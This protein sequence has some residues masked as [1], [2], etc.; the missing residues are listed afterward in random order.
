MW[1]T[2]IARP[3]ARACR[4]LGEAA[5]RLD[6]FDRL[7]TWAVAGTSHVSFIGFPKRAMEP[8]ASDWT[9]PRG[10][11][12]RS[13]WQSPETS[14]LAERGALGAPLVAAVSRRASFLWEF[15]A[16]RTGVVVMVELLS[17]TTANHVLAADDGLPHRQRL[18]CRMPRL[19][20]GHCRF[21]S[22]AH[23]RSIRVSSY[24]GRDHGCAPNSARVLI[25]DRQS[26][27]GLPVGPRS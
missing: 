7:R 26:A 17:I 20:L 16:D 6:D 18:R 9:G 27:T 19:H 12:R 3:A 14:H 13:G 1:P 22:S 23:V 4:L 5:A 25:D 15:A 10:R 2:S 24:R 11:Q 8:A 21:L